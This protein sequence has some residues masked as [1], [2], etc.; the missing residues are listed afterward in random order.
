M[1]A[2]DLDKTFN[3]PDGYLIEQYTS[4][5]STVGAS[6]AIDSNNRIVV[7]GSTVDNTNTESMFV[8]RYLADGT[9]DTDFAGGVITEQYTSGKNTVGVSV[10]IDSNNRIVV[11]GSTADNTGKYSMFV[12]RYLADGTPDTYFAGGVITE[13]Y[14]SG[15]NTFGNS[16]AIDSNNSVVVTG[17]TVDNTDKASMFVTRYLADGTPDTY[18]AGGVITEQYTSG[19]NTFG[20]SVAIDSNNSVVVTG[21]TV[22]NTDKASMFVTRY[23]EDGTPDNNFAG[24][25]VFEQYTSGYE[26]V[27]SSVAIDSNGRVVV[28]GFTFDTNNTISMFLT[29]YLEDGTPDTGFAGGVIFEQYTS[30]KDTAGRSV[31]ID[32]IGRIVVTGYTVD[33]TDAGSMFITRYLSNGDLDTNFS[34]GVITKQYTS[35]K[36]TV[37]YSVGIDSNNR[38]V[39]TGL[40]LYNNDTLSMFLTRYLGDNATTTTTTITTLPP[41]TT[42][43]TTEPICLVAGTPI[44][45]DQG[46]VAIEKIDTTKH[47]INNKRIVAVTKAISPEKHLVCFEANSM[48]INCPTQRTIMTP[49]HEVLYKGKLVQSKHFVGRV[50]GVHT[51]PYNGKDVLYNVLQEQHGLM[52]VNNMVLET[53]HPENKVA[54][55]LLKK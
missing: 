52:R 21:Y 48:G 30:G 18:F 5:K 11:T 36:G 6:V 19:K 4:G 54:K 12:T 51:I 16:V 28:T 55:E 1:S 2:G 37:G 34:G 8:T 22:D 53:L 32:S 44:L 45:T 31:A 27:G 46:I 23:L 42:T 7:T 35:G 25:V 50:D 13:Q 10:A 26:T 14:T 29:R 33:N 24:G 40:T 49:G 41:T 47:T 15:K 3:S 9:L 39:V 20:N 43:T 38:V 17:Y